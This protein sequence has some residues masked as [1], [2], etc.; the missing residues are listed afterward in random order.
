MQARPKPEDWD[1]AMAN[2]CGETSSIP[3]AGHPDHH[4]VIHVSFR[5]KQPESDHSAT[6]QNAVG[7]FK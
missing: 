2:R 3:D 5:Y 1:A 7:V 6:I 4:G